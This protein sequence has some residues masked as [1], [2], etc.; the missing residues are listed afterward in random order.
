MIETDPNF[1]AY[2]GEVDC[3]L[4]Y[5]IDCDKPICVDN[6]VAASNGEH[7]VDWCFGCAGGP[8]E[9]LAVLEDDTP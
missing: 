4:R 2:C 7:G 5:C 3:N 8:A 6:C 1:C 9:R